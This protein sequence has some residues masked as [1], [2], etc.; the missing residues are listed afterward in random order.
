MRSTCNQYIKQLFWQSYYRID[1]N[2]C[3]LI[4]ALCPLTMSA[5]SSRAQNPSKVTDEKVRR[6][7]SILFS[8]CI[9]ELYQSLK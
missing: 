6:H 5:F 4:I 3:P 2:F 7:H 9:K 8:L 1:P